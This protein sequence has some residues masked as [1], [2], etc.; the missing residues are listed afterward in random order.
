MV[1]CIWY[2]DLNSLGHIL[3]FMLTFSACFG[4]TWC[5]V[6]QNRKDVTSTYTYNNNK[7]KN[8]YIQENNSIQMLTRKWNG[9]GD[10]EVDKE[11]LDAISR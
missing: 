8:T 1:L 3:L 5:G 6:T 10:R 2:K 9:D 11:I 7:C 4:E